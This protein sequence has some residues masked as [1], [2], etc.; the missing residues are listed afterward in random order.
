MQDDFPQAGA[1]RHGFHPVLFRPVAVTGVLG[2][3]I[4]GAFIG[5]RRL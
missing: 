2:I 1:L 3:L 5:S 4:V